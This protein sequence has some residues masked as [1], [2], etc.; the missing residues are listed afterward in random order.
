MIDFVD[1][2]VKRLRD[3][4]ATGLIIVGSDNTIGMITLT[5]QGRLLVS[6]EKLYPLY[7]GWVTEELDKI[8]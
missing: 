8:F 6:I 4:G 1:I 7:S 5:S 3:M 2:E